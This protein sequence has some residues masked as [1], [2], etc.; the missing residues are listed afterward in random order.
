MKKKKKRDTTEEDQFRS[1][2]VPLKSI[3][4]DPATQK[5]LEDTASEINKLVA[6]GYQLVRL[7]LVA[8]HREGNLP[9][10]NEHM[11]KN[12]ADIQS[13][14]EIIHKQRDVI[15]QQSEIIR[16]C[17]LEIADINKELNETVVSKWTSRNI[18]S[19]LNNTMLKTTRSSTLS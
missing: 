3:V 16:H 4:R 15:H 13:L 7:F 9:K 8:K 2:K 18:L 6:L 5:F 11:D 1:I 19:F 10:V 12:L 17:K 14:T